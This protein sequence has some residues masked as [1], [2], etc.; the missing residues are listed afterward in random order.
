LPRNLTVAVIQ[1]RGE[2]NPE[3][4]LERITEITAV[5]AKEGARL[6]AFPEAVMGP[7]IKGQND[8]SLRGRFVTALKDL[9]RKHALWLLPGTFWERTKA[10][11]MRVHNTALLIGPDGRLV[12]CYRKIHVFDVDL[13]SGKTIRESDTILPGSE[14]ISVSTAI[15]HIGMGICFDLRFP[16]LFD[17]L[18][19]SRRLDLILLPSN[20]TRETG[21]SHFL[22]LLR[23]RAI[24]QQCFVL[25]PNQYG[26]Q[27]GQGPS[28][29]NST[30]IDPWGN[31][32]ARAPAQG[33]TLLMVDL[34][35]D[36]SA[37]V[38]THFPLNKRLI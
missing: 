22:P 35:L 23:A 6:V 24:E 9:A 28:Y 21:R 33:D 3:H 17:H 32:I 27:K 1:I 31:V 10:D 29:G 7:W 19:C 36:Q 34:D 8:I 14:P 12:G 38:R 20:F 26:P 2:G 11:V 30:I 37:R 4:C 5:A 25:A 13:P 15:G 16:A 18:A